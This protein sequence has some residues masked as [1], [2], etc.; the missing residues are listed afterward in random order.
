MATRLPL[1]N[2]TRV[3]LYTH[4][5]LGMAGGLLFLMWF[6]TG[7]VMMYARMPYL[8]SE[9]RLMRLSALDL[10][11]ARMAP[12]EAARSLNLSP[13]RV[14][15]GM[16]G[17]RPVYRFVDGAQWTTVFA[18]S[19]QP[20]RGLTPAE[21][22][23]LVRRFA[24]EHASTVRYDVYLK[25]ADQWTLQMRSL[26]PMHRVALGDFEDTRLYI[27]DRTAEAVMKTTRSDRRW[28]YLGAVPHWI[29]FT[30]LRR[31]TELWTRVVMW[32]SI[33]GCVLSLTGLGW[34][35]WRYS[36][37]SRYRLKG[38]RSHTPYTGLLRWHHYAGLV[39]GLT[40]FTWILS[41][42]LS[43]DPWN[44]H[45]GTAPAQWQQEAVAGGQLRLNDLTTARMREGLAVIASSFA[46]GELEVVQFQGEL[47]L[48]GYG[49]PSADQARQRSSTDLPAFPLPVRPVEHRLVSM[50]TPENG[51]FTRFDDGAVLAAARVAM[52]GT[53][54]EEA[55]WLQ[56]YYPYYYDR[57]GRRP[58]PVLRVRYSDSARTWLYL[59]P[60]R[61]VIV[62]KEEQLS[63]ANRWL[64]HGLHS[65]DFPFLY[66]RRPLWDVVVIVLS[67]GGIL[68]SAT[69]MLPAWQRV[70]RQLQRLA[71]IVA[72]VSRRG[73]DAS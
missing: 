31:H 52:P 48:L 44:W 49:V 3:I 13:E 1:S 29:Y 8:A 9:D 15:V 24:P 5:W 34:G 61:G 57:D 41:G 21:T 10:S 68:L 50:S 4:R 22:M 30:S 23:S 70:W 28:A 18:D 40:T 60:Q 37:R 17:D 66:D 19:G 38:V 59:D 67:L 56:E 63:R 6:V 2:W 54:I 45:P 72:C 65:F 7:I 71:R 26:L 46:P 43:L 14:Q 27:S 11:S 47:F 64:Y 55:V 16:L 42:C 25:D 58:L 53:A 39:F 62:Q 32:L 36:P 12:A 20:L 51:T 35:L 33:A 69:T 73:G